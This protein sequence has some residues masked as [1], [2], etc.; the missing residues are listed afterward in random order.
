MSTVLASLPVPERRGGLPVQVEVWG[1]LACFT[2]PE[3]KVERVSYPVM[4]PSAARGVLEA[5]FW[6]PEMRYDVTAVEVLS[7]M[8]WTSV[9]RNE[10]K[11]TIGP[12]TVRDLRAGTGRRYDTAE[13]R[14]QRA[15]MALRDVAYRVHGEVSLSA[16]AR[17][18]A[19][20]DGKV[21]PLTASKYAD[22]FMRRVRRG[23]C[24]AQPFLGCREFSAGFGPVGS[25][26]GADGP[27]VAVD[28]T[29]ELGVMLH[30]ITYTDQGEE[31]GWFRARLER[32]VLLVPSGPLPSDAVAMPVS[33]RRADAA[34]AG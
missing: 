27:A 11:S 5:V 6:K 12:Q 21:E 3:L 32:G 29:E 10:V 22:Q 24:F 28:R 15:T 16:S 1:P 17:P 20:A 30:S 23:A 7:P 25:W 13:D 19:G 9:R 2:R 26:P 31:Y 14:V 8:A 33:A 18:R 34:Q 4:T